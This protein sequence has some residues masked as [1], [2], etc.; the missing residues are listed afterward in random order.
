[1]RLHLY[2]TTLCLSLA[3][4]D[5]VEDA[6]ILD[7]RWADLKSELNTQ[8]P[9][10]NYGYGYMRAPWNMNPSTK[11]TRFTSTN[12]DLPTCKAHYELLSQT[13]LSEFL[14]KVPYAPHGST[15]CL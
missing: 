12:K 4:N 15:V 14:G 6:R 3:Q 10:L 13:K 2:L 5:T 11:L 9:A 1:M 8:F 7:G